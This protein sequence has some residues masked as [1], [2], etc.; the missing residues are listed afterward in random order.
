MRSLSQNQNPENQLSSTINTFFRTFAIGGI[1]KKVGAYKTK[2]TPAVT[3][4]Q[5][6]FALVFFHKSLFMDINT[7]DNP[8]IA[9]DTFYRFLDSCHINWSR[10]SILLAAR[11]ISKIEHL[12]DE[13]RADV[14]I[15]DDTPFE[16]NR[17]KKVELL[18]RVYDHSKKLFITGFRLLTLG[19]SDGNTFIPVDSHLLSSEDQKI[20]S[21]KHEP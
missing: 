6:L 19:W 5:K 7:S 9:K 2:G 16:R 1:L 4:L 8:T 14:F 17:S 20:V 21:K 15:V 13:K 10:F 12:T 18:C 11:I 3:V